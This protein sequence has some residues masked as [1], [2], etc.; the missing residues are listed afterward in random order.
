MVLFFFLVKLNRFWQHLHPDWHK[1]FLHKRVAYGLFKF[2]FVIMVTKLVLLRLIFA[3]SFKKLTL[4]N[5]AIMHKVKS[6][7]AWQEEVMHG[8]WRKVMVDDRWGGVMME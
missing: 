1:F 6:L 2:S 4:N 7:C 5:H 3:C 8:L